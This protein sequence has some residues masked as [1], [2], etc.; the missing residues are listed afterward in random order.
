MGG[1]GAAES[2]LRFGILG[3]HHSHGHVNDC[4]ES[5]KRPLVM[6]SL[7]TPLVNVPSVEQYVR[8]FRPLEY[9]LRTC[10]LHNDK[11]GYLAINDCET[12][13]FIL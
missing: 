3:R 13:V 7:L 1:G 6:I 12:R 10:F 9:L 5:A 4:Y 8:H 11:S 2:K